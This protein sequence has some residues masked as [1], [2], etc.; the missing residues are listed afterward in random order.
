MAERTDGPIVI[1]GGGMAG[2]NAAVTLRQEGYRGRLTLVSAE[3]G[4]PF[5]RPP[6]SK[7]YLRSEES[8]DGWYVRPASWYEEHDVERPGQASAATVDTTAGT[9]L[10]DSGQ[11]LGYQKLLIATGGRPRR[12]GLPGADLAGIHYL[13]TVADCDAIKR[14]ARPG[15]RAAVF[16]GVVVVLHSYPAKQRMEVIRDIAGGVNIGRGRPA[17]LVGEQSVVLRSRVAPHSWD[18]HVYPDARDGEVAGYPPAAGGHGYLYRT[19]SLE[20]RNLLSGQ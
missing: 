3:P 19:G 13:R 20:R 4:V 11:E 6:L 18:D 17:Q 2:G 8:L 12:L 16:L 10:L 15:R 5:G 14:D 9:V 7:T 1:L